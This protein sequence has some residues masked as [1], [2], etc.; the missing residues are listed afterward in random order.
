MT[1]PIPA[2]ETAGLLRRLAAI[3]YDVMVFIAVLL[4]ATIPFVLVAGGAPT[5]RGGQLAY[6]FYVLLIGFL[7]FGW[8]WVH[9][10]QTLGMRAWR[11]RLVDRTGTAIT[12]RQALLHFLGAILSWAVFGAGYLWILVDR[13]RLS[14]HD[15]LSGTRVIVIP[16]IRRAPAASRPSAT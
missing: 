12:W 13:D 14:W 1:T 5:N 9:G 8:F 6:Q 3:V 4:L 2:P 15:R 7:F 16:K 11:L 10:G